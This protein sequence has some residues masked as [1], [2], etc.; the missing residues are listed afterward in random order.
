MAGVTLEQVVKQ[1]GDQTAVDGIDLEIGEGEFFSVLGPSGCGKTTT[2]RMVAGF[3][4]PTA[5]TIRIQE[6]DVI[7]VPPE[8]R[9]I[10]I[11]FQNYAIFPHKNIFDNIAFG[12]RMRKTPK[13]EIH[14]RVSA[15]LKQVGLVGYEGRYQSELSGGEQ[16][17]VALARVL[18]TEPRVL[19]LDEPLSALDRKLRDEMRFWLKDLQHQLKITTL[20]VTHDQGE[21]LILSDR[22]AVMNRGR[23]EQL[24]TPREIYEQPRT[25]FVA[26]FIG[27]INRIAA[28]VVGID[29]GYATLKSADAGF[30]LRAPSRDQLAPGDAVTVVVRPEK[31]VVGVEAGQP[32]VN[33]FHGV[34]VSRTYE[35]PYMRYHLNVDGASVTA[36][37]PNLPDRESV[38]EGATVAA[39]WHADSSAILID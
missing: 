21:A 31:V 15:A 4:N 10:G 27:E 3:I 36:E 8:K 24:G 2:L 5:G 16:Q 25:S 9:N 1:Y 18:V 39:G 17:R 37:V 19:L 28:Q 12:L 23:I 6:Q 11:V 26:D 35:G 29:D 22:I 34:V 33:R 14:D 20:Y 13:P 7:G 30:D 38:A 32:G